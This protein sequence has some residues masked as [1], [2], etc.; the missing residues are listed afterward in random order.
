MRWKH[1]PIVAFDTETTGLR[2]FLGDRVI[3]FGAI[4]FTLDEAGEIAEAAPHSWLIDPKIPIPKKVTEITGIQDADV[5][6]KPTFSQVAPEIHA[7]L[8]DCVA[9]AHNFPFDMA[10]LT[11]EFSRVGLPWPEPLAEVDTVDVSMAVFPDAR[12]HKLGDL[13]KRLDVPLVDAHRATDDAGACGRAFLQMAQNADITDDLQAMLDWARA[14][15]RPPEG[16]PFAI[17]DSGQLVF[18]QGEHQSEPVRDHP[19]H[20]AGL[21]LAREKRLDGWHYVWPE[22]IRAWIQRWL[23][24]RGAGRHRPSPKTFRADDWMLDPCI[25][26]PRGTTA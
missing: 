10:F 21:A 16:G 1:L 20:L 7:L 11:A 8:R 5:A 2:P 15:G 4:V 18:T 22:S 26:D 24:V 19:L 17:D 12:S 23:S 13:C 14:V 6:G 25:S 9:V 3:E